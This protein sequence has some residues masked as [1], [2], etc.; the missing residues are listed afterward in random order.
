MS[1]VSEHDWFAS[2]KRITVTNTT[3]RGA[4]SLEEHFKR[5]SEGAGTRGRAVATQSLQGM[6]LQ[7][8]FV[9]EVADIRKSVTGKGL[10][11]R[12]H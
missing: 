7:Q 8:I 3:V 2:Y 6:Y 4:V 11:N 10:A 9:A 12:Q 5:T 1:T